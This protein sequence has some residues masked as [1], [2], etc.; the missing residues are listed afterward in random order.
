[1][2]INQHEYAIFCDNCKAK[3]SKT[4]ADNNCLICGKKLKNNF[5]IHFFYIIVI[6]IFIII[7]FMII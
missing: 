1:M 2:I 6:Y 7:K 3:N 4:T 5:K